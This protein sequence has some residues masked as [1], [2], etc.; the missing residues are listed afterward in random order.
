MSTP[1]EYIE[2]KKRRDLSKT[3]TMLH[4]AVPPEKVEEMLSEG[5]CE[6]RIEAFK[7]EAFYTAPD[8]K[9]LFSP[10]T[11]SREEAV[12]LVDSLRSEFDQQRLENIFRDTRNDLLQAIAGPFGL[13]KV[14]AAYDK[15]G[16]NVTTVHNANNGVYANKGDKYERDDYAKS[17]N[18]QG[19]R[20]AGGGKNSVGAKFTRSKMDENHLVR[21]AYTGRI[22]KADTTSP[23]HI[24]SLSQYHKDGGFM[25]TTE[26]K[27]DFATDTDNLALTDRSINQSM[28]DFDKED[29][30]EKGTPDIKNREKFD[31]D[32]NAL[33]EQIQKGKATSK[34]HLPTDSEK[35]KYYASKSAQTGAI[36]GLQW[37][38]SKP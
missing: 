20:F 13:G 1:E 12:L 24:E 30:L 28:R 7:K 4:R 38:L 32:E 19:E 6:S 22:Q 16:G 36:E 10:I 17:K 29:W 37:G 35:A 26:E 25:Q 31:I 23:D 8:G 3:R 34:K 2:R 14:V 11:T 9:S 33:K 18:S 21:D 5:V 15:A 27:A